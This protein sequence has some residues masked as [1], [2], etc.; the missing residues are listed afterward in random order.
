MIAPN[1][2]P[3]RVGLKLSPQLCTI[4]QLRAVWRLADDAGFDHVWIFDHFN[5][6]GGNPL[7]G[8]IHEGW[9][10]L[11]AMAEATSRVR[12]GNMVTGNT[13]RHPGVLAKIATTVDHLSGGRLEFGLGA[14]WAEVEHTMLGLE[15]PGVGERLRRLEE[16]CQVVKKLWT[17]ERA[18]FEGRYYRLT[19]AL[20]MPKPLQKPYP[21]IWIGGGGE[22]KT[23]RIVAQ[24]ADV[25]NMAGGSIEDG[26]HKVEVLKR[27]CEDVGR[28]VAE[29]RLSVQLRLAPDDVDASLRQVDAFVAEGF[30][31][32]VMIVTEPNSLERAEAVAREILPRFRD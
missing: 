1:G 18:D 2:H 10:L 12:I 27:H 13:Y 4:E 17:E 16:A 29:I 25:W 28:D 11:G 14:G 7:D 19:G 26:R 9:T 24:H 31:E 15:F 5:P 32:L 23:L 20:A 30:T 22:R 21:P 8:D 6:I 3:V